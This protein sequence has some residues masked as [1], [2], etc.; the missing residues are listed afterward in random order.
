MS[1]A[2]AA[3]PITF[4]LPE[5]NEGERYTATI[6][7]ES[8]RYH[9]IRLP[10]DNDPANHADQIAWA[11]SIGGDLPN[12]VESAL[13]YREAKSEFQERAYWTNEIDAEDPVYAWCQY[14]L[15]GHQHWSSTNGTLRARAVRRLV[16]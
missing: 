2:T 11:K 3:Q 7:T 8:E 6:I 5:L 13:L 1:T 4:E 12:R 9:L 10:G 16:V 14:F 15:N